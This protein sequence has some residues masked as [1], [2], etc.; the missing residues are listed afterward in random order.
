MDG[1]RVLYELC[2]ADPAL[3]FSPFCWRTRLAL[4]H[5]GLT[6]E[7]RPWRFTETEAL[8][9]SGQGPRGACK[10]PVLV[11]GDRTVSDS[12]AIAQY[13]EDAYPEAPSL[14]GPSLSGTG[15]AAHVRFVAAW[16]DAVLVPGIARLIVADV[17][18]QLAPED[19]A[20]F[21]ASRE[22]RFKVPLETLCATREQDVAGFRATL[23]PLRLVLRGQDWLGGAAADYAD[24]I[25]AGTLMWPRT[26]SR[27][28]VLAEDD[29]IALWFARVRGLFGGM[30]ERAARV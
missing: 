21:R 5:K 30:L 16:A 24:Y 4:A 6:A 7:T 23:T 2:A 19:E 18:A 26:V 8:A 10:V 14:F 17:A 25:V 11:D 9:F 22:A 20:Y 1:G 3:L 27:F 28:A 29:P 12:W 13:L 15:G